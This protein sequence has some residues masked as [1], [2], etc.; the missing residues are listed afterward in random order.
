MKLPIILLFL[1][2]VSFS[3]AVDNTY[4]FIIPT[5]C[6]DAVCTLG[7]NCATCILDCGECPVSNTHGK[8]YSHTR[9]VMPMCDGLVTGPCYCGDDISINGIC[10]KDIIK[11]NITKVINISENIVFPDTIVLGNKS[12]INISGI[13]KLVILLNINGN[14]INILP[15]HENNTYY[16]SVDGLPPGDYDLNLTAYTHY[17]VYS[18]VIRGIAEEKTILNLTSPPVT[19]KKDQGIYWTLGVMALI[20]LLTWLLFYWKMVK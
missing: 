7:E 8:Q 12:S 9:A 17:G 14:M 6:G 11:E 3:S 13:D 2:L 5:Y 20:L 15:T 1:A 4:N 10:I 16:F 19:V 18:K